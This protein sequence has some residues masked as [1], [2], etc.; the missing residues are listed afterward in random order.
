VHGDGKV[1]LRVPLKEVDGQGRDLLASEGVIRTHSH[2]LEFFHQ[3]FAEYAHARWLLSEG[4][5]APAIQALRESVSD[6]KGG[7]WDIVASLLLQVRAFADYQALVSLFPVRTAQ[8]ARARAFAALRRPEPEALTGLLTEVGSQPEF[9]PAM[10]DVLRDAPYDR[11]P[12]A[13]SWITVALRAHPARLA[14]EA[15]IA[16]ASLLPRRDP[17]DV[18]AALAAALNALAEA[19]GQV[20]DRS[21]W[22][23]LTERMVLAIND[24]PALHEALPVLRQGYGRLGERGQ[25]ATLRAHLAQRAEL[26]HDEVAEL[27]RCALATKSPELRDEEAVDIISLF[28]NEPS[29][30]SARSWDSLSAMV[31]SALPGGWQNGQI[32]FAVRCAEARE[33]L[34]AELFSSAL[35]VTGGHPVNNVSAVKQLAALF[36]QW[37]ASW[38][39][40]QGSLGTPRVIKIIN[41]TAA[42][43][44]DG[45]TPEQR[46]QIAARLRAARSVN[47]RDGFCAEIILAGKRMAE[48]R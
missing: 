44:A 31:N 10:I 32:K 21:T 34:R 14:K 42:S 11:L 18:P 15:A 16:L 37:S 43:L 17:A 12:E 40:A 39:L 27:A 47:P 46:E 24:H 28:W 35:Q 36:P 5:A 33:S 38:L 22:T 45:A 2:D 26:S 30:R 13:Y 8:G 9:I 7:S 19:E 29:V 4:I 23:T 41:A 25:Q 20:S 3:T 6:G 48:H 1:V